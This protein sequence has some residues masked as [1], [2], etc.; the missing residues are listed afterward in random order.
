MS[1]SKPTIEDCELTAREEG[2]IPVEEITVEE[3][4]NHDITV[5]TS[6]IQFGTPE[7]YNRESEEFGNANTWFELVKQQKMF[8]Y[9]RT[10]R[11]PDAL[12][13]EAKNLAREFRAFI[14]NYTGDCAKGYV[15][16]AACGAFR[17]PAYQKDFEQCRVPPDAVMAIVFDGGPIAPFMNLSYEDYKAFDEVCTFFDARGYWFENV[18]HWWVWVMKK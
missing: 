18:T 7:F 9:D 17:D 3:L 15:P 6:I 11:I 5:A 14:T 12:T 8:A 13:L 4:R 2:W 10:F 1:R 16:Y